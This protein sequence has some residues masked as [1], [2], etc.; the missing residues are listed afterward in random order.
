MILFCSLVQGLSISGKVFPIERFNRYPS[1]G[2]L[3]NGTFYLRS[4]SQNYTGVT[5]YLIEERNYM[6]FA[7][8]NGGLSHLCRPNTT[9]TQYY[10]MHKPKQMDFDFWEETIPNKMVVVPFIANCNRSQIQYIMKFSNQKTLL[11]SREIMLP[12]VYYLFLVVY[13]VVGILWVINGCRHRNFKV[14][15]HKFFTISTFGQAFACFI[16]G[17]SWLAK[18][19]RE[20]NSIVHALL[21]NALVVVCQT[22][23]LATN[24]IAIDGYTILKDFV[25]I[26]EMINIYIVILWFFAGFNTIQDTEQLMFLIPLYFMTIFVLCVFLQ[27]MYNRI[28]TTL[29]FRSLRIP[30]FNQEA[31]K[32]KINLILRFCNSLAIW[33]LFAGVVY[34]YFI[35]AP[36]SKSIKYAT[37]ELFL[38]ILCVIDY[39]TFRYKE[40]YEPGSWNKFT[41]SPPDTINVVEHT[42]K[43][44][45]VILLS[46]PDEHNFGLLEVETA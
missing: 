24:A 20:H 9:I 27:V 12:A 1:F 44:E 19:H 31:Y 23:L 2:Y 14:M 15:I 43:Q 39:C 30:N 3:P 38:A 34:V 45:T 41:A 11:D 22:N 46:E 28:V 21:K 5:V 35:I 33:L 36:V 13:L 7:H 29:N 26:D 37:V 6:D 8:E 16:R 10:K 18:A 40:E 4:Y 25:Q 17:T 42:R 32:A